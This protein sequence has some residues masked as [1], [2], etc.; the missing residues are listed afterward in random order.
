MFE[1]VGNLQLYNFIIDRNFEMQYVDILT[2]K[3]CCVRSVELSSAFNSNESREFELIFAVIWNGNRISSMTKI[4]RSNSFKTR[5]KN[6]ILNE[7][8]KPFDLIHS[9]FF[10]SCRLSL[11]TR[12]AGLNLYC[13]SQMKFHMDGFHLH[14]SIIDCATKSDEIEPFYMDYHCVYVTFWYQITVFESLLYETVNGLLVDCNFRRKVHQYECSNTNLPTVARCHHSHRIDD[15]TSFP[16]CVAYIS[17]WCRSF[18]LIEFLIFES[19]DLFVV[20]LLCRFF[21]CKVAIE[22][23]ARRRV[24]IVDL[25]AQLRFKVTHVLFVVL[26]KC[27]INFVV[28][29]LRLEAWVKLTLFFS[30]AIHFTWCDCTV[31]HLPWW[32]CYRR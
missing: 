24:G 6:M 15:K 18:K 16:C 22:R 27:F 17:R 30:T 20:F 31:A 12:N 13:T 28:F 25:C 29:H 19:I 26:G 23:F 21:F 32:W 9:E 5:R 7:M 11:W 10:T 14:D 2:W 4:E 8:Q 1:M 3:L